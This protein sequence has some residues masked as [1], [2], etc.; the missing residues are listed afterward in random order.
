MPPEGVKTDEGNLVMPNRLQR[1]VWKW[2]ETFW[3]EWVPEVTKGEPYVV[4]HNGD[5]IDGAHHET[6]T[7]FTTN[8]QDQRNLAIQMLAP[9][10]AKAEGYYHIR[11]TS[12]HVGESG[13][14]SEN[15]A[16]A[17]R[18]TPNIDGQ[19]AR[20]E[21]WLKLGRHHLHFLHH[22]GV[23]G[24]SAHE[25]SAVNAELTAE[26]VEASRWGYQPPSVIVRS[27]RHREIEVRIPTR[28]G[29]ATAVVT[30]AWQL[31]TSH[32]FK[33]AGARLAPPQIGG[34]LIRLDHNGDPFTQAYCHHIQ[35]DE[36]EEITT[37]KKHKEPTCRRD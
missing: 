31:K 12:V 17:L 19:F 4:V 20:Y 16:R 22:V 9:R 33:I 8:L 13:R 24:S 36:P 2:W 29:Y 14:E 30:P 35:R 21:L 26:F 15:I 18:A 10:I 6:S 37:Q 28:D 25:A 34:I 11:G 27:H 5:D 1:V 23:T 3:G 32:C 7:V